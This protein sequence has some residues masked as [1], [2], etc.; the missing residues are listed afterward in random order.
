MN[1]T[2]WCPTRDSWT[3]SLIPVF[4]IDRTGY[5]MKVL[6][7]IFFYSILFTFNIKNTI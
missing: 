6:V 4:I 3:F 7:G 5:E 1:I 2:F